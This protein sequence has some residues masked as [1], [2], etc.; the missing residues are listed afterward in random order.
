MRVADSVV[1]TKKRYPKHPS[2]TS[3]C[4]K[5]ALRKS[6]LSMLYSIR[7]FPGSVVATSAARSHCHRETKE[8]SCSTPLLHPTVLTQGISC[9]LW[10]SPPLQCSHIRLT[11]SSSSLASKRGCRLPL[12]GLAGMHTTIVSSS[13]MGVSFRRPCSHTLGVFPIA[14]HRI[15]GASDALQNAPTDKQLDHLEVHTDAFFQRC[16]QCSFC[17]SHKTNRLLNS[18]VGLSL[19][20]R[21]SL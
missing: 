15:I 18:S 6:A 21:R 3:Q 4:T 17:S 12:A 13:A 14:P 20:V 7:I 5:S 1:S 2:V 8:L 19:S 10:P 16:F 11:R 9:S